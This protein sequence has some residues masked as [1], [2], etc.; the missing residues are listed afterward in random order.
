MKTPLSIE[1]GNVPRDVR[2]L[3]RAQER[4]YVLRLP[5]CWQLVNEEELAAYQANC[6]KLGIPLIYDD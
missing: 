2:R 3:G 1:D 5:G 6:R 4:F